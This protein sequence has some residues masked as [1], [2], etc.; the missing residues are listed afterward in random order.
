MRIFFHAQDCSNSLGFC[1]SQPQLKSLQHDLAHTGCH[2]DPCALCTA[3]KRPQDPPSRFSTE[4]R[5]HSNQAPGF[6]T[7]LTD[8]RPSDSLPILGNAIRF[9]QPRHV[10]FDW[11]VQQQHDLGDETYE[12]FVPSLPPGVVI[13]STENL[14]YVLKNESIITK[15]PFFKNRSWDLFGT[16]FYKVNRRRV[17]IFRIWH[18]KCFRRT[19]ASTTQSWI[20]VLWR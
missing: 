5:Q 13:S 10:L 18:H 16:M 17:N 1:A 4:V 20:E 15:G 6:P 8:R 14:E 2:L 19:M 11:F 7:Y 12:I 3:L 9:L